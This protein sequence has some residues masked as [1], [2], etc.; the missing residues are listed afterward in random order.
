MDT[1]EIMEQFEGY[2][3]TRSEMVALKALVNRCGV[4]PS[5]IIRPGSGVDF[6]YDSYIGIEVKKRSSWTLSKR[7]LKDIINLEK[8]VIITTSISGASF[9]MVVE[10]GEWSDDVEDIMS[11]YEEI[12]NGDNDDGR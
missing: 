4:C 8:G 12:K 11:V 9:D 6:I 2:S 7:Q 1:E 3:F 5:E 10:G